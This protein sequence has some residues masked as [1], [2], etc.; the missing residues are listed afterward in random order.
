[1]AGQGAVVGSTRLGSGPTGRP[2]TFQDFLACRIETLVAEVNWLTEAHRPRHLRYRLQ[3]AGT[4]RLELG[5]LQSLVRVMQA[6]RLETV[7]EL[8]EDAARRWATRLGLRLDR[9]D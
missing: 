8:G 3:Y 2:L 6:K 1:M 9:T 5:A 7:A 4:Q